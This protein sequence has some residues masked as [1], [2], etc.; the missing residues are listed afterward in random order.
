M[1]NS[2]GILLCRLTKLYGFFGK[3]ADD[4]SDCKVRSY[5]YK[6]NSDIGTLVDGLWQSFVIF[7]IQTLSTSIWTPR[8]LT[9]RVNNAVWPI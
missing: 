8:T 5:Q 6:T 7:S 4:V 9:M 1:P 2:E 3:A